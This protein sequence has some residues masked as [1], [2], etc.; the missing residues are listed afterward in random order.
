MKT[1]SMKAQIILDVF[2]FVELHG[3][4]FH[5]VNNCLKY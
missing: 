1:L 2:I 3:K 5:A 4:C